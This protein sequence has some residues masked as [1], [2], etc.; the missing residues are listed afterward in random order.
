MKLTRILA[1]GL[2]GVCLSTAVLFISGCSSQHEFNEN[3]ITGKLPYMWLVEKNELDELNAHY[4]PTLND[5]VRKN[6]PGKYEAVQKKKN[7]QANKIITKYDKLFKEE[8][9]RIMGR[10]VTVYI[11]D[12]LPFIVSSPFK[13]VEDKDHQF[14]CAIEGEIEATQDITSATTNVRFRNHGVS[15]SIHQTIYGYE[16][17]DWNYEIN[18][19]I[20]DIARKTTTSF[21]VSLQKITHAERGVK[22]GISWERKITRPEVAKLTTPEPD[23]NYLGDSNPEDAILMKEGERIKVR[24]APSLR[25]NFEAYV[26]S[27]FDESH[28]NNITVSMDLFTGDESEYYGDESAYYFED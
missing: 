11:D 1:A 19:N 5:L 22:L 13:I 12:N 2:L 9:Q 17:C 18:G 20:M 26:L 4:Q 21:F 10:E 14:G 6:K 3:P 16:F 7:K 28:R 15:E 8:A 27:S 23:F 24:F 25:T